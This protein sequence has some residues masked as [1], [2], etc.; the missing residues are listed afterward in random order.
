MR[1]TPHC[2]ACG[3][4]ESPVLVM[5]PWYT[6][7]TCDT[8]TRREDMP[9]ERKGKYMLAG[10]TGFDTPNLATLG[11]GTLADISQLTTQITSNAI[12]TRV[13]DRIL[14]AV[15][16]TGADSLPSA[17][18]G[19][20]S[21]NLTSIGTA[22]TQPGIMCGLWYSV[23]GDFTVQTNADVITAQYTGLTN[24]TGAAMLVYR[25]SNIGSTGLDRSATGAATSTSISAGPTSALTAFGELCVAIAART[26]S[27]TQDIGWSNG[28][29]S[30]FSGIG[31][32]SFPAYD[33]A[34]MRTN[35]KEAVTAAA[36]TVSTE[37]A[38]VLATFKKP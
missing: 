21:S 18:F 19:Q 17:V 1:V 16:Q 6:C 32:G 38:C 28:F 30:L 5:T 27:Q 10:V 26:G 4:P 24:P 22:G 7:P 11:S 8:T 20:T 13:N 31:A 15:A 35:T 37:W 25:L 14:V 2:P 33:I 9:L 36:S 23:V 3:A 12:A 34:T 29:G